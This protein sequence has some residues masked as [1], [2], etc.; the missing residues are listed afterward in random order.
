MQRA[1]LDFPLDLAAD[2]SESRSSIY[3]ISLREPIGPDQCILVDQAYR[4][5]DQVKCRDNLDN[6]HLLLPSLQL[7]KRS[8]MPRACVIITSRDGCR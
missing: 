6:R 2:P 1:V 7:S 4:L 5:I 8:M 3:E